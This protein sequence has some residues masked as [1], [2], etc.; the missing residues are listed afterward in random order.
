MYRILNKSTETVKSE[1]LWGTDAAK[2]KWGSFPFSGIF[3]VWFHAPIKNI[4]IIPTSMKCTVLQVLFKCSENTHFQVKHNYLQYLI[5]TKGDF[6]YFRQLCLHC[7]NANPATLL[8]RSEA[9]CGIQSRAGLCRSFYEFKHGLSFDCV[10]PHLF[11]MTYL[12]L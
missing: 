5:R 11:L 3:K 4:R 10:F 6:F 8:S 12:H 9:P 1:I 7:C 2:A